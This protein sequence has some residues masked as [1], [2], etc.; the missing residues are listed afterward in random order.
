MKNIDDYLEPEEVKKILES[1]GNPRDFLIIK[2]LWETGMR[3][4]ELVNL[5]YSNINFKTNFITIINSKWGRSRRV[6]VSEITKKLLKD[7]CKIKK[8]TGEMNLFN[9][10]RFQI[11]RIV[12]KHS[13]KVGF[14]GVHPHTFRH[15]FAINCIRNDMN[16][17]QLQMLL[18]HK[19]LESTAVY[20]QFKDKDLKNAYEKVKFYE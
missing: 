12:I 10:N 11:R 13:K 2:M 3:V 9:I 20:L 5:K 8:I 17:R 7:Y 4:S 14:K 6:L 16:I 19:D 15:S 18:G 1:V